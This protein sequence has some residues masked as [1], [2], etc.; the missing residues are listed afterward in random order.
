MADA[1]A[2]EAPAPFE[3]MSTAPPVPTYGAPTVPALMG[4]PT[5][6]EWDLLE[7]AANMLARSSLIPKGLQG[8]PSD[9]MVIALN[10][11]ELRIPLAY[12]VAKMHVIEGTPS[13]SAEMMASLV[14]RAGHKIGPKK[15]AVTP[16]SATVVA[17]RADEPGTEHE[18]TFTIAD[19]ET[20]GLRD[21]WYERWVKVESGKSYKDTFVVEPESRRGAPV[22][23]EPEWVQ[24]MIAKGE[25][26][27]RKD[28][29]HQYPMSMLWA[30]AV[31]QMVRMVFTDVLMGA[32]LTPEE[33]GA[34]VD[35]IT[36]EIIERDSLA[37]EPV[38]EEI[39]RRIRALPDALQR[40]LRE[41]FREFSIPPVGRLPD[42]YV[43]SVSSQLDGMEAW[44]QSFVEAEG[45]ESY[46]ERKADEAFGPEQAPAEGTAEP[47]P[48]PQEAPEGA[49][50]PESTTPAPPEAPAP[51]EPPVDPA[52]AAALEARAAAKAE[53]DVE[54]PAPAQPDVIADMAAALRGKPDD[55]TTPPYEIVRLIPCNH[56]QRV[57]PGKAKEKK[58]LRCNSCRRQ[59]VVEA[60]FEPEP[61]AAEV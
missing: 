51:A 28:N 19:A 58:P 18:F 49:P 59:R 3:P 45:R 55:E 56:Q 34:N 14:R 30:R 47:A 2:S 24:R 40:Q 10:A 23:K 38:R 57:E 5:A 21:E 9:V 17:T 12:A 52:R 35:P 50:T 6:D 7:R 26:P 29:W 54:P 16:E 39:L 36:G 4:P 25:A 1:T 13:M 41:W 15:G 53:A 46:A 11:R 32:T 22:G 33:L 60:I 48:E 43:A 8:K 27:K 31:S 37:P 61:P 20:A 44:S 42:R